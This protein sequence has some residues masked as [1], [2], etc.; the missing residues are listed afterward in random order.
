MV[1]TP[2]CTLISIPRPPKGLSLVEASQLMRGKKGSRTVLTIV[3]DSEENPKDI[4][5]TRGNVKIRSIKPTDRVGGEDIQ[6]GAA[7]LPRAHRTVQKFCALLRSSILTSETEFGER[8]LVAPNS[9]ERDIASI[10]EKRTDTVAATSRE[11]LPSGS[12]PTN[13]GLTRSES[14]KHIDWHSAGPQRPTNKLRRANS[15]R[16]ICN[17]HR[18]K[19]APNPNANSPRGRATA[20]RCSARTSFCMWSET[21]IR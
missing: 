15:S 6:S 11:R 17:H 4:G 18:F 8:Y 20:S 10:Q 21:V 16:P 9:V 12:C 13:R 2:F 19:V 14:N 5:I 1:S 7:G 3:R